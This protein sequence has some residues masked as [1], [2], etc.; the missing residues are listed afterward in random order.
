MALDRLRVFELLL[1]HDL[2]EIEVGDTP[3]D[4]HENRKGKEERERLGA[5]RLAQKLPQGLGKRYLA[6]FQEYEACATPESRFA[7]AID[8]LDAVLQEIDYKEDWKGWTK[9]FLLEKKLPL[10]KEFPPLE[11]E[12]LTL[13]DFLEKEGYFDQ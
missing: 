3:L 10:F 13:L 12:F 11:K 7:K 4:H 9:A 2:V 5:E 6:L 8:A 1:Y